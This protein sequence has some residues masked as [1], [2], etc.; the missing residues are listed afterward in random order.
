VRGRV[1]AAGRNQR[2]LEELPDLGATSTIQL[3]QPD[4]ALASAF[5]AHGG[6]GGYDV[7]VDYV[8]G[9]PTEVLLDALTN[10][11]LESRSCRTRLVQVGETAGPRVG[12]PASVLRSTRL[13]IMGMGTGNVPPA[14]MLRA[15]MVEQLQLLASGGLRVD[16]ERV[17]L[18]SVASV[19]VRDQAG[20]RPVFIP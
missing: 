9:H 8:W 14:E 7:V 17:P 5:T 15:A 2:V 6:D 1:V 3:D 16:I 4:Q 12:L 20:R 11:T 19:W 18:S 13:E 10:Y